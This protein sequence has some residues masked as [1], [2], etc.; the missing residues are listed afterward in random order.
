MKIEF[1]EK[2][3]PEISHEQSNGKKI[4]DLLVPMKEESIEN[5][6]KKIESGKEVVVQLGTYF[7]Y[8]GVVIVG[9]PDGIYFQNGIPLYLFE[10]KS[11]RGTINDVYPSEKIQAYLYALALENMGFDTSQ[12]HIII[13][14]VK[15]NIEKKELIN[16][17]LYYLNIGIIDDFNMEYPDAKIYQFDYSKKNK[18]EIINKL[19]NLIKFWTKERVPNYSDYIGR[20]RTCKYK[21]ECSNPEL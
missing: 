17:I 16:P 3:Q 2:Y 5:I 7:N 19:D 9:I 18:V 21:G 14:K 20:C 6:I 12:L 1:D 4:H 10:L 8:K 15:M 13:T 11:T